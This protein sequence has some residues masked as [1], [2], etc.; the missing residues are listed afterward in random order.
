MIHLE[1]GL[2]P[3]VCP[4]NEN[5][6]DKVVASTVDFTED[7]VRGDEGEFLEHNRQHLTLEFL[8]RAFPACPVVRALS[9]NAGEY[10][11]NS[12]LGN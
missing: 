8:L 7:C 12:W 11:F 9:S 3:E 10:G 1:A 6:L 4:Q 2:G 5:P